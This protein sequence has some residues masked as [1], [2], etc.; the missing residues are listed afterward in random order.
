MCCEPR[1][2]AMCG[3]VQTYWKELSCKMRE[4]TV[5]HSILVWN[6][7]QPPIQHGV[8]RGVDAGLEHI[9]AEVDIDHC[10]ICAAESL[11]PL[12]NIT[13]WGVCK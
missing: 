8:W 5:C 10:L 6:R 12:K 3:S 4:F 1:D 9:L 11:Q 2:E 13:T 7:S